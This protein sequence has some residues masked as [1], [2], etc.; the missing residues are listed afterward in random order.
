MPNK[1]REIINR[2][3]AGKTLRE[4]MTHLKKEI[5]NPDFLIHGKVVGAKGEFILY[6]AFWDRLKDKIGSASFEKIISSLKKVDKT[7]LEEVALGE[8]H[9]ILNFDLKKA[10]ITESVSVPRSGNIVVPISL[11]GTAQIRFNSVTGHSF[12]LTEYQ[13]IKI[14]YEELYLSNTAQTGKYLQ[15]L[16]GKGDFE[17]PKQASGG[18]RRTLVCTNVHLPY[19]ERL[20]QSNAYYRSDAF[21]ALQYSR[22]ILLSYSTVASAAN[23]V[24]IQ[25]SM[26]G[27]NWDYSTQY[28]ALAGVGLAASVELV[29]RYVRI[30]YQN[31]PAS[32]NI[33]GGEFRLTALARSMP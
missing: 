28:T 8:W 11:D 27:T 7:L 25:Q 10:R 5:N 29:A 17:F 26:D 18:V 31:G 4:I 16:I 6:E 20:L 19:T 1:P 21:D 14:D 3:E 9:T 32:Q 33:P 2:L 22:V 30:V 13:P 12:D 15:L 23:G 24:E